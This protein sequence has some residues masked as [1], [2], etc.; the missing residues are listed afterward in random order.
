MTRI[1]SLKPISAGALALVLLISG[2][3]QLYAQNANNPNQVALLRWYKTNQS[4]PI[5]ACLQPAALAFDGAHMWVACFNGEVLEMNASDGTLLKT[6]SLPNV[7][8]LAY[9]G[10]DI[11]AASQA[12]GGQVIEIQA[13][14][15]YI[16][17]TFYTGSGAQ[18]IAFDG[19]SMWVTNGGTGSPLVYRYS[20]LNEVLTGTFAL[21]AGCTS[22]YTPAVDGDHVWVTCDN[23]PGTVI[24]LNQNGRVVN[25]VN[26]GSNPSYLAFDGTFMWVTNQESASVSQINVST[27][28][29]NTIPVGNQPEGI[30]FDTK[31]IWVANTGDNTITRI[32]SN[33]NAVQT[34]TTVIV[35]PFEL[36]FDGGNVWIG[37]VGAGVY[38]F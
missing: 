36:A 38:K 4:A 27:L 12:Y 11:W 22:P 1:S 28:A 5:N 2:V 26:V 7:S 6:F 14:T 10:V 24:E 34:F 18:G 31:F 13:S 17:Q 29:V 15:G 19:T 37:G 23:T 30:V 33:T 16:L 9:D 3:S 20:V 35:F 32:N 8:G 25:T 21:P